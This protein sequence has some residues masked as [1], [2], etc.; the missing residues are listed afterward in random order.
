M[1][2]FLKLTKR[3]QALRAEFARNRF[4]LVREPLQY[5][6]ERLPGQGPSFAVAS[7][8]KGVQWS[9]SHITMCRFVALTL[10]SILWTINNNNCLTR[11]QKKDS[12]LRTTCH[13]MPIVPFFQKQLFRPFFESTSHQQGEPFFCTLFKTSKLARRIN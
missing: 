12:C 5:L 11:G 4:C 2:R 13:S 9:E 10:P 8:C 6:D 3:G 7:C 1:V